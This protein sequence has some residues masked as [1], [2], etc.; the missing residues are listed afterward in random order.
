MHRVGSSSIGD[1]SLFDRR[2]RCN[3]RIIFIRS[4]IS[5]DS[6]PCFYAFITGS[7]SSANVLPRL[8]TNLP[9]LGVVTPMR[10]DEARSK[11]CSHEYLLDQSST[12]APKSLSH[13]CQVSIDKRSPVFCHSKRR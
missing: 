11:D 5:I 4:Q 3:S 13:R 8:L 7:R 9:R 10:V 6:E 1:M 2:W 12:K